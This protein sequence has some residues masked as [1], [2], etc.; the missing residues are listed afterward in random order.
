MSP[1]LARPS[2][3]GYIPLTTKWRRPTVLL[4][5]VCDAKFKLPS[6]LQE[7]MGAFDSV[8]LLYPATYWAE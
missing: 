8:K 3:L 4:P 7:N 1:L 6:A 2:F 5:P